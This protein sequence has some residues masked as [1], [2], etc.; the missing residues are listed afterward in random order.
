[1]RPKVYENVAQ[2]AGGAASTTGFWD[3]PPTVS[4]AALGDSNSGMHLLIG[5]L[6]ALVGR[7]KT[8]KGQKVAVVDAGRGA[9]PVPGQAAR[10]GAPGARRLPGGVPAVSERRRSAIR[11]PAAATPAAAD[12]PA[13]WSSARAGR[14]TPTPTS[15]SPSRSR[16]GS[17]PAEAIGRPEWVDDP[18]YSTATARQPHIFDIFGEIEKWL[19]DKTKYEAVDI[20][21]KFEVPCAPVLSMKEIA[22]DPALRASGSIVEVEQQGAGQL[23]DGRQPDQVLGVHAGD[24]RRTAAGRAHRRGLDG[25]GLQRGTDRPIAQ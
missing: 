15:T 3:G 4:G 12:S 19:A 24:H 6:T 21:R 5:I 11:S 8:G 16:T 23:P 25:A 20:L 17:G 22:Y 7:E 1:M 13:G 14:P 2:C 18:A 9:E 10:P